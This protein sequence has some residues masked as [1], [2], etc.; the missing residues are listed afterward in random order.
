MYTRS[1]LSIFGKRTTLGNLNLLRVGKSGLSG[2]YAL[3]NLGVDLH[4][5]LEV[6]I[7]CQLFTLLVVVE[8]ISQVAWV[9]QI[10]VDSPSF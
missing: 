2:I 5:G 6:S 10:V 1:V 9:A 8:W 7:N 4:T 3:S